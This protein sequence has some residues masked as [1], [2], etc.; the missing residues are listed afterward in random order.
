MAEEKCKT[1]H[2]IGGN[3]E[4]IQTRA[5]LDPKT[6]AEQSHNIPLQNMLHF[7]VFDDQNMSVVFGFAI[8]EI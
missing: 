3:R 4:E 5:I 6:V 8:I 2:N 1:R 7:K